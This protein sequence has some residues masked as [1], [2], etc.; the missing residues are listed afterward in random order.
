[1]IVCGC[2]EQ[3][4]RFAADSLP[5]SKV[6]TWLDEGALIRE[7]GVI[8]ELKT[9]FPIVVAEIIRGKLLLPRISDLVAKVITQC[10][11]APRPIYRAT[12][13]FPDPTSDPRCRTLHHTGDPCC[14]FGFMVRR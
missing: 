11:V 2:F 13:R 8:S 5:G 12:D 10:F 7:S 3:R 4:A 14:I 9:K 6:L 1:M